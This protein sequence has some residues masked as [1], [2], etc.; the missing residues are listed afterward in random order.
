MRL[1]TRLTRCS[2]SSPSRSDILGPRSGKGAAPP[3]KERTVSEYARMAFEYRIAARVIA[4]SCESC[5]QREFDYLLHDTFVC[6]S[7]AVA[8]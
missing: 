6:E 1:L 8:A 5:E 2:T 3:T 7:C 4:E